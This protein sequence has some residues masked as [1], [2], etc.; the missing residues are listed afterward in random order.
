MRVFIKQASMRAALFAAALL[1]QGAP[2]LAADEDAAAQ[3]KFAAIAESKTMLMVPM[4]DG[5]KLA[6]DVYLSKQGKGPYPTIFIRTPYN[7]NKLAGSQLELAIKF[8]EH[9]YAVVIQN[10]RGR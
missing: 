5:V 1:A 9:G 4:R 7:F 8:I 3:A 2:A 10:E 6:T